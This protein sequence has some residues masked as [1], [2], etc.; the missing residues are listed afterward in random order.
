MGN[1]STSF[2]A[3]IFQPIVDQIKLDITATGLWS[4]IK[5]DRLINRHR[6]CTI[7][8]HSFERR[9]ETRKLQA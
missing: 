2:F 6:E 5:L 9:I 4:L 1:Y 3:L 8:D 7:G